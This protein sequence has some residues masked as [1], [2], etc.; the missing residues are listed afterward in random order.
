MEKKRKKRKQQDNTKDLEN[1]EIFYKSETI[2][3]KLKHFSE[4]QSDEYK[5]EMLKTVPEQEVYK[6]IGKLKQSENIAIILNELNDDICKN[7]TF[8]YIAKQYK[9]NSKQLLELLGQIEFNVQIPKNML[10]LTI[11]NLNILNLDLLIKIQRNVENYEHMKFKVNEIGDSRN[12][13]YSFSEISAIIAKIE[14]LTADIPEEMDEANKFYTIYSRLTSMMTYN[15]ECIRKSHDLESKFEQRKISYIGYRNNKKE[16]RKKAAGLYGGLIDGSAICAGYAIILHEA[17][18]YVGMKSQYVRGDNLEVGHA[19]IQVQ[20]DGKWYNA[21]PTW[22]SDVIQIVGKYK[23]ML[24]SDE[25]F[26]I[27]HSE[28]SFNRPKTYHQCKS[29][30]D[31]SKIK[32]DVPVEIGTR[33]DTYR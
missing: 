5:M 6:F 21:D 14:E 12:I 26:E 16:I 15:H 23:Y 28:Y 24:L 30:F 13:N 18:Q 25:E 27:S 33:K 31:Y 4:V 1:V 22:D 20:I 11:N 3:L 7:K 8:Q 10:I 17:L 9:G 29:N 32:G 19:W 2:E